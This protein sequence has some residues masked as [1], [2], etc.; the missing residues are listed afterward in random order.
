[1]S[2]VDV[3]TELN[4]AGS[5]DEGSAFWRKGARV[6]DAAPHPGLELTLGSKSLGVDS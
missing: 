4:A 2:L 6:G 5:S 3:E 1:M